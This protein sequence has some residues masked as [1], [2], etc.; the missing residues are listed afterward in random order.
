MKEFPITE[1]FEYVSE[2]NQAK[3]AGRGQNLIL[4]GP[5]LLSKEY[6]RN[7][8]DRADLARKFLRARPSQISNTIVRMFH[9]KPHGLDLLN[10]ITEYFSD[11]ISE[12]NF[13]IFG[14]I[15]L[16]RISEFQ[17]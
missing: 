12:K 15:P 17:V 13:T 4:I 5:K 16:V 14:K 10:H 11:M 7:K 1:Q 9:R 6:W 8:K 2:S 3:V